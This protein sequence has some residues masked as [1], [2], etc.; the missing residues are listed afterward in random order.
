VRAVRRGTREIGVFHRLFQI[1]IVLFHLRRWAVIVGQPARRIE[2][3][4]PRKGNNDAVA[5]A[6]SLGAIGGDE[7]LAR[8]VKPERKTVIGGNAKGVEDLG[9]GKDVHRRALM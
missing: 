9:G 2:P 8:V 5:Q 1:L 6:C 3:F 4:L 7:A